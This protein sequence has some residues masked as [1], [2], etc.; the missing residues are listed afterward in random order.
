MIASSD[1]LHDVVFTKKLVFDPSLWSFIDSNKSSLRQRV[2][3]LSEAVQMS[4]CSFLNWVFIVTSKD[5]YIYFRT[6]SFL[7]EKIKAFDSLEEWGSGRQTMALL[8]AFPAE[9]Y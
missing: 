1:L 9:K 5:V 8:W 7:S 3:F 2:H 4:R 6:L